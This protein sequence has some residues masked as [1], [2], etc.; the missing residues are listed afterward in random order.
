[1]IAELTDTPMGTVLSRV[2]RGRNRLRGLLTDVAK[3][4]GYLLDDA[5]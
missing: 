3:R 1:E 4:R 5:A 2:H